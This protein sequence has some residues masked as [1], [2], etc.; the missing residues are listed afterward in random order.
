MTSRKLRVYT[1][2]MK[3]KSKLNSEFVANCT[4]FNLRKATRAIT[5]VFDDALKPSGLYSTQFSLLAAISVMDSATISNLS[6]ALIMD[7]TTLT[8]NLNP[9]QENGWV[10]VSPGEDRRTKNLSLTKS[11][12]KVLGKAMVPW[13]QTQK[14]I[15]ESLGKKRWEDLM[16]QLTFA[17]NKVNPY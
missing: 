3:S 17:V 12:K 6:Q 16:G 9:L 2:I 14:Q 10:E 5:K 1:L 15:V 11:G 8:R 4:C 13:K 7:R